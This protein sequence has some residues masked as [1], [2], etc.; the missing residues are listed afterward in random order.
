MDKV[1]LRENGEEVPEALLAATKQHVDSGFLDLSTWPGEKHPSQNRWHNRCSQFDL[2][3]AFSWIAYIDLD[4]FMILMEKCAL[5]TVER[6]FAAHHTSYVLC[7]CIS[8]FV[9]HTFVAEC[10][11]TQSSVCF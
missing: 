8:P 3:G 9:P 1:F 5:K 7:L 10:K 6:K 2:A 4:E 11:I